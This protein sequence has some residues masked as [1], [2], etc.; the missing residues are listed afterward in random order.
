MT[1]R[2]DPACRLLPEVRRRAGSETLGTEDKLETAPA[3]APW[4]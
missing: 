1:L 2:H 4:L 3:S